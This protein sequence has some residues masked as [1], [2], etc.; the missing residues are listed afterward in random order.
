MTIIKIDHGYKL[1]L[2]LK[3]MEQPLQ[4]IDFTGFFDFLD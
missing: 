4:E 2:K 3:Y 1:F